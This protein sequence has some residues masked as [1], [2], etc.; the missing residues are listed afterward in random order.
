MTTVYVSGHRNP[1]TDS[2]CSPLAYAVLKNKLDSSQKYEPIR[3]GNVSNETKFILDYF[4]VETPMLVKDVEAG[5]KLILVDHNEFVQAVSGVEKAELLEIVDH[6]KINF[7]WPNPIFVRTETTG[8]SATIITKMFRENNVEIDPQTAGLLMSAILSDSLIFKSPTCTPED[9]KICRELAIIADVKDVES[10]GLEMLKAGTTLA[11]K[12]VEDIFNVDFKDFVE[13]SVKYGVSQVNTMDIEGFIQSSKSDMLTYMKK[14]TEKGE[15]DFL[16]LLLTDIIKE[17][18]L[19][20]STG[21]VGI[22]EAAFEIKLEDDV[23]YVPGILSRK[24]QVIPVLT[25]TILG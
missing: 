8:C 5:Q 13:G 25:K 22:V 12:T 14:L 4:K 20:I 16:L 3:L 2:I 18:S 24:K 9:E 17:G 23:K 15:Y 7:S 10:Y 21:N 6:H 11:G 19:L 1:D